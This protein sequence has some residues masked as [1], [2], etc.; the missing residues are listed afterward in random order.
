MAAGREQRA[1]PSAAQN[2]L[3]FFFFFFEKK[4]TFEW[5]FS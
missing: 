1:L 5:I 2:F 4:K 3:S